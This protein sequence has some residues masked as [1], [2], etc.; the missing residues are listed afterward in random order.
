MVTFTATVTA[1]FGGVPTGTVNFQ[2]QATLLGT[3]M[4]VDGVASFTTSLQAL[5]TNHITAVYAGDAMNTGSTS[6][7]LAQIVH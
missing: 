5:G 2:H 1:P 7:T 3:A 6:A 4:L